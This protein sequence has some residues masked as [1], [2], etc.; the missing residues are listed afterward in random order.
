MNLI[1]KY[2]VGC[3]KQVYWFSIAYCRML[4]LLDSILTNSVVSVVS[5]SHRKFFFPILISQ[6]LGRDSVKTNCFLFS[7]ALCQD[8]TRD[9]KNV[10][11]FSR[12]ILPQHTTV[13][14]SSNKTH[15]YQRKVLIVRTSTTLD[16]LN[17]YNCYCR[18]D[19]LFKEK[20]LNSRNSWTGS[21]LDCD[22]WCFQFDIFM[23]FKSSHLFSWVVLGYTTPCV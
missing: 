23:S 17:F 12:Q 22:L 16:P 19:L 20:F 1:R 2:T 14:K 8:R 10:Q 5:L 15:Q 13:T 21:I 7:C 9:Q 18:Q 11:N 3:F 4:L 6:T